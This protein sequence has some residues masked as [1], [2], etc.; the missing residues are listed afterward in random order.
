MGR[1][2]RAGIAIATQKRLNCCVN[3]ATVRLT[4]S[5]YLQHT[6]KCDENCESF[7]EALNL[8]EAKLI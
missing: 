8:H 6:D 5:T 3:V 4:P 1:S 7:L 2:L